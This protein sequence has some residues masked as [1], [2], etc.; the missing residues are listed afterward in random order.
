M[1]RA[2]AAMTQGGRVVIGRDTRESGEWITSALSNGLVAG[3]ATALDG[4]IMPTAAV[5]CA[6]VAH[7]A[8][9]GVVI[10]ASHNPWRDNGIKVLNAS[11]EKLTN[12]AELE[13]FFVDPP[14]PGGGK[15]MHLPDAIEAW[16]ASMPSVD[17]QGVSILLDCAH[18]AASQ[19]AP[20]VLQDMGASL[21]MV[22]CSPDG[23]NINDGV[24]ATHPPQSTQG[25]DIAICLDGDADRLVLIDPTH[26][27]LDGD[28]IL[29]MLS[30]R[31]TGPVVGT[32]M[33]NG[34]LETALQGR[35]V[36]TAVG[37]RHV[38]AAMTKT[39]AQI[40]AET[41]GH[42]LFSDGLPTGDG[43]YSAL[44]I[45]QLGLPMK[46]EG[47]N[48]LT[49]MKTNLR[50]TGNKIDLSLLETPAQATASGHRVVVR[51]SG[52]EPLLRIMI[53]GQNSDVWAKQVATEFKERQ[54]P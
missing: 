30:R 10:T 7:N 22:G 8:D 36:R 52:T 41:S 14:A 45:L 24:G 51:Y 34:G 11:G 54:H 25:C 53:E 18:G 37:D 23:R 4:G 12:Q 43:L 39:G 16:R 17:L 9:A 35:L 48:R 40:G 29:W 44:R 46:T 21:K 50:F 33:T 1:G 26:G 13:A 42:V 20:G 27:T 47:W 38:A 19:H 15:H 5:S 3:G 49:V 28:D 32:I 2:I 31:V 6:V